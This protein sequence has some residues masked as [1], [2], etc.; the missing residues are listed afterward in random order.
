MSHFA[1]WLRRKRIAEGLDS[2]DPSDRFRFNP[3]EGD[4]AD[5]YEK[6]QVK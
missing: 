4:M 3:G 5:D 6:N 2:G 1:D